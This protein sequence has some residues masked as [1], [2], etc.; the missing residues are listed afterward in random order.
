MQ[1]MSF[2][3]FLCFVVACLL[4]ISGNAAGARTAG[5]QASIV[6][7]S[8][9]V[10]DWLLQ[11]RVAGDLPAYQHEV[12]PMSRATILVHLHTLEA[13]GPRFSAGNRHLLEDFLNEFD[14]K[15]LAGN[16]AFTTAF[17]RGLPRSLIGAIR[18]RRDPVLYA[19]FTRDSSAS[20]AIYRMIGNGALALDERDATSSS[21]IALGGIKVIFNT[22]FGLGYHAEMD[23]IYAANSRPLIARIP[24]WG[25]EALKDS[26]DTSFGYETFLSF[27]T[28]KYF[29]AYLGRGAQSLGAAVV[30]PLVLRVDAPFL[31]TA[32]MQIGTSRLNF[33]YVHTQLYATTTDDTLIYQG[34]PIVERHAP[35]RFMVSHRLT[36]RPTDKVTLAAHEEMVYAN[37][38]LEL[39][40]LVPVMPLIFFQAGGGDQDNLLAGGD[41][42][43]RPW[44]GTELLGSLLV[45]DAN[46]TWG[47]Y[48]KISLVGIEQRLTPALR[49]GASYTASDPWTYTHH[50]RLN[51]WETHNKPLGAELGPNGQEWAARLTAWLPMRTRVMGGYRFIRRG[52]NPVD[53]RGH[54]IRDVGGDL[55]RGLPV[56]FEPRY[57]NADVH[58]I[59]RLELEAQTE[60]IRGL[61]F[62]VRVRNDDVL[63]GTQLPS[64][65]FIDFRMR[66]GF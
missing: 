42:T 55:L 12:R 56:N 3:R 28:K 50:F 21:Y 14:M 63:K 54:A 51:T 4:A 47:P 26:S 29:E 40:Y 52:L 31:G 38:G 7:A 60:F 64:S 65:R 37:R 39:N 1:L 16:R 19:G 48:Q 35:Q 11:Q 15:R 49:L 8:H 46:D 44:R 9:P 41:L 22:S 2:P 43:V 57:R 10:Y 27:R 45:D 58:D 61:N 18:E 36:W 33:T 17:F 62:S 30:D 32:R 59:R 53:A 25:T 23:N 20:G 5:A 24:R 6:P 66:F 13:L 34:A